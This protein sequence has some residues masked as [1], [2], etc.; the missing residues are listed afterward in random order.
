MASGGSDAIFTPAGKRTRTGF[1]KELPVPPSPSSPC[2]PRPQAYRLPLV[3]SAYCVEFELAT[4]AIRP[5]R[6]TV[7]G[8]QCVSTSPLVLPKKEPQC[9]ATGPAV[10]T[11][12]AV[13][14]SPPAAA[15][16]AVAADAAAAAVVAGGT[17]AARARPLK[18]A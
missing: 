16:P 10:A 1:S 4:C 12:T 8:H 6:C 2:E 14:T 13:A 7:A 5:G 15:G 18:A 11:R 9:S 17:G 3:S